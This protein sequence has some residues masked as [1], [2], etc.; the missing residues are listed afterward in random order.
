MNKYIKSNLFV[1]SIIVFLGLITMLFNTL[2]YI[3]RRIFGITISIIEVSI[4]FILSKR[5]NLSLKD[6]G[7]I[8]PIK[9]IAWI[10]GI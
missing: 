1:I 5:Q 7:I 10:V 4:V 3:E 8:K 9:P 6:M 2:N